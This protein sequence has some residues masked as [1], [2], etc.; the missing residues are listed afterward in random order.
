[1]NYGLQ[2]SASGVLAALYQ[3]DVATNN[4]ANMN[5]VGFKPDFASLVA[6]DSA[7]EE[8]GL[9]WLPS[10]RLLERLGAGVLAAPNRISFEQGPLMTTNNTLDLAIQGEGFFVVR[11]KTDEVGD[12]LRLSRDGRLTRDPRGLLVRSADGLPILDVNNRVIVLPEGPVAIAGDGTI[13]QAGRYIAQIQVTAVPDTGRLTKTGHGMFVTPSDSMENRRQANGVVR[14]GELESAALDPV[15]AMMSVTK[16][17]SD[18][19]R[20]FGM[21]QYHDRMIDR[22]IN[23]FGRVA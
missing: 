16:A 12:R 7:S 17:S 1:M 19:E 6:R 20:N 15:L 4:L 3:Q 23:T 5:T 18:A 9:Q 8:D 11:E 2:I 22:A 21:I 14:Q 10:N 13:A